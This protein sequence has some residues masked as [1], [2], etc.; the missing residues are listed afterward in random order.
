[1]NAPIKIWCAD[2]LS[3]DVHAQLMRLAG[4]P[5][6]CHIA[7]MPDVHLA[8]EVCIGVAVATTHTLYP[9]AVGGDIGCGMA[10]VQ[11]NLHRADI[12]N[13]HTAARIMHG[14]ERLVPILAHR[15]AQPMPDSLLEPL[16]A[17]KL[18]GA[19]M[20]NAALQLGTLGRGNHFLELQ[21]DE[22][23]HVWACVHTGSRSIGQAIRDHY[24]SQHAGPGM[25]A[26]DART[27]VGQGYVHDVAW[28]LR[29][30]HHNRMRILDAA[31]E[32][33]ADVAGGAAIADTT[34]QC[35]HNHVRRES[36]GGDTW[37][38]HRKGAVSAQVNESAIIPGSMGSA[39]FHTR[40][41]GLADALCSSSHGAGRNMS[42][43]EA[44]KRIRVVELQRSVQGLWFDHRKLRQLVDE[45]PAA[46]KDIHRVMRAQHELTAITRRLHPLLSFKGV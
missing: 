15:A 18:H 13:A 46:Y 22:D 12:D 26:M 8:D 11:L 21:V 9:S 32:I 19:K 28:A 16:A 31:C 1:M 7:V 6:V 37:W 14:F 45:A 34:I 10:A 40:G 39:T 41:R 3:R 44:R 4:A 38:V 29:Y 2:P 20:H 25:A 35:E 17:Q 27:E 30:A 23:D 33:L 5:D 36:M 24:V 43:T 42:R